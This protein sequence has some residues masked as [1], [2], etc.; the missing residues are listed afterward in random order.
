MTIDLPTADLPKPT[1]G[2]GFSLVNVV[3]CP[4]VIICL[5]LFSALI[6]VAHMDVK[7]SEK[8]R[9][10]YSRIREFHYFLGLRWVT[11]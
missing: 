5:S 2:V 8:G 4:L 7:K 9:I 3:T 10:G 11:S 1:P 6:G